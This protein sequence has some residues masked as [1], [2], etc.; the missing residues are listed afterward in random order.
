MSILQWLYALRLFFR[1]ALL[2]SKTPDP[3]VGEEPHERN[4]S[5]ASCSSDPPVIF[6]IM[7]INCFEIIPTRSPYLTIL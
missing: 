2:Q 1:K 4:R 5:Q 3:T 7:E 6:D